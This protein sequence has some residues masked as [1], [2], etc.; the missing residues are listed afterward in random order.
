MGYHIHMLYFSATG[1]TEK[2]VH[3]VAEKLNGEIGDS[4][5]NR[6]DFTLPQER[7]KSCS[8]GKNDLVI[9]G[10]PVYAGRV[11]NVLLKYIKSIRGNGALAAAIVLY[12]NR[13]YED[14]LIELRDLLLEDG[15]H[16]IAGGAFIGEHS[17]SRVL[18]KG[19]PDEKDLA[20]ADK[21]A[22]LISQK[23][24]SGMTAA[25]EVK[26]NTPYR[27]YYKPKDEQ[28][29]PV[30]I[31]KVKPKTKGNCTHCMTCVN[32]CPMGS[33]S[34]DDPSVLTGICIKCGACIKKCPVGAKYFDDPDFLRHKT[35]MEVGLTARKEP[36]LF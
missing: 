19:R 7:E 29:N 27:S 21:F 25:V 8:F 30:D 24:E 5:V 23:I 16:V 14:A 9:A 15:F 20:L 31:R 4:T 26:G 34:A 36:E 3:R 33:I 17:F 11:P 10:V 32:V 18:A 35:E 28:K 12:G 13:D 1:T 2:I 22:D 6:V